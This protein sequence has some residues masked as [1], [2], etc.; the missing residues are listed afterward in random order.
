MLAS[1]TRERLGAGQ[2]HFLDDPADLGDFFHEVELGGQPPGGV[3]QHDVDAADLGGGDGVEDD[4]GRI[5]AL[6]GDHRDVVAFAPGLELFRAAARNVPPAASRTPL[7]WPL[8]IFGQPMDVV[9]PAPLTP[10]S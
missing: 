10:R 9:L 4:G 5:A 1:S 7:P 3:G 8:E 6:L 2:V